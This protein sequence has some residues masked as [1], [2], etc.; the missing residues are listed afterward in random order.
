MTAGV[1]MR[2]PAGQNPLQTDYSYSRVN[3]SHSLERYGPAKIDEVGDADHGGVMGP[4]RLLGPRDSGVLSRAQPSGLH[5]RA[6]HGLPAGG[7]KSLAL[8]EAYQ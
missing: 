8:R 7:E 1:A 3:C 4:R 2:P 5:N 6:D